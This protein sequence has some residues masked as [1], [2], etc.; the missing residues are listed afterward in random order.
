MGGWVIRSGN[1]RDC[2]KPEDESVPTTAAE[3]S[4]GGTTGHD[5]EAVAEEGG[6]LIDQPTE[7]CRSEK[8][9]KIFHSISSYSNLRTSPF[10]DKRRSLQP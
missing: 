2:Q 8:I 7:S 5:D 10:T 4:F 6:E 1:F 9:S 3:E